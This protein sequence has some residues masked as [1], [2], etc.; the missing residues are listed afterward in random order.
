MTRNS[1]WP[2]LGLVLASVVAVPIVLGAGPA[3]AI[4][5]VAVTG[6]AFG[7][8]TDIHGQVDETFGPAPSVN[9]PTGG[10]GPFSA[11]LA[12]GGD[13]VF[14][15]T[16][17]LGVETEGTD[18]GTASGLATSVA[19][20]S[21]VQVQNLIFDADQV[22][23]EC[24]SSV[25]GSVG[26]TTLTN[27]FTINGD[28]PTAPAPNTTVQV[29][30]WTVVVNEQV[31]HESIFGLTSIT[32]NAVHITPSSGLE[33]NGDIIVGQVQCGAY[34]FDTD[35]PGNGGIPC[36]AIPSNAADG[37]IAGSGIGIL[38]TTGDGQSAGVGLQP[39]QRAS[40]FLSYRN[41][42]SAPQDIVVRASH[43]SL[44]GEFKVKAFRDD[45]DITSKVFGV[46]G[47]RFRAVDSGDFTPAVRIQIRRVADPPVDA[48]IRVRVTGNYGSASACADTV[49]MLGN[50]LD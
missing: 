17:P 42:D 5:V 11:T 50:V 29:G 49:R 1:R 10:G 15:S 12:S 3:G 48:G 21:D 19:Q 44:S 28:L 33:L 26:E 14:L 36:P 23:S 13:P 24:A 25:N 8:Q 6:S 35:A 39:G 27:A 34:R 4:D 41:G 45:R 47:K 38:N 20:V 37:E 7:A 9:L 32:V 2:T 22:V 31:V 43:G 30:D 16:G 40:E 46:N 18:V